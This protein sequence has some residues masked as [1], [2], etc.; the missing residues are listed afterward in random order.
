MGA[1][2]HTVHAKGMFFQLNK[3]KRR[4]KMRWRRPGPVKKAFRR[5]A[6]CTFHI[7]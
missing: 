6:H 3:A 5:V 4:K 1:G 7:A 2:L